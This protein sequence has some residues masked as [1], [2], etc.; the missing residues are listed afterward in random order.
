MKWIEFR[1]TI[2]FLLKFLGFYLIGNLIY[3]L[4]VTYYLP[5]ADPLTIAVT[6]QTTALLNVCGWPSS[7]DLPQGSATVGI[8]HGGQTIV[9]VF[10]GCN[11]INVMV[12]FLGFLWAFGPTSRRMAWFAVLGVMIIH[13]MNLMRVGWLFWVA[14]ELPSFLYF[15]H[16]Y[17][18]TASIYAIVF[19]LW[20]GWVKYSKPSA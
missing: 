7:I 2:I 6:K 19:A 16:K 1:P 10:E 17:L 15:S 12:I 3:G 20:M 4:F 11:G 13:L 9:S 8:V 18:F 14:L 5:N